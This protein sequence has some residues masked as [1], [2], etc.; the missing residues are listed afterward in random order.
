MQEERPA[1][2]K[3]NEVSELDKRGAARAHTVCDHEITD[4]T[5]QDAEARTATQRN[6]KTPAEVGDRCGECGSSEHWPVDCP[7]K[8]EQEEGRRRENAETVSRIAGE[9]RTALAELW[10]FNEG[11]IEAFERQRSGWNRKVRAWSEEDEVVSEL[12]EEA[13]SDLYD[14]SKEENRYE[15]EK[16]EEEKRG[17]EAKRRKDSRPTSKGR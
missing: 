4:D 15:F 3:E 9:M 1:A 8:I 2:E 11:A 13:C 14:R 17:G 12:M 10:E 6:P 16:R 5:S 7:R